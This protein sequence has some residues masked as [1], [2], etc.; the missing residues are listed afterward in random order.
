[1][2]NMIFF[3]NC[4]YKSDY[5]WKKNKKKMKRIII[6]FFN[7]DISSKGI[8]NQ[9]ELYFCSYQTREIHLKEYYDWSFIE[10]RLF[11]VL[12]VG[13][14]S[15]GVIWG[16]QLTRQAAYVAEILER[17]QTWQRNDCKFLS[18]AKLFLTQCPTDRFF[19]P[20]FSFYFDYGWNIN[21]NA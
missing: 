20:N 13:R 14:N 12:L 4:V 16:C 3:K 21:M 15:L 10:I 17:R 2:K 6:E 11:K 8:F 1:M 7:K 18:L 9:I 19:F 5:I